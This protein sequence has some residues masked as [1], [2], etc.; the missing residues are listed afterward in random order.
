MEK[1]VPDMYQKSIY[2]ID[3]DKLLRR[4]I[5][6][7]LFDLDNT[8]APVKMKSPT[9][10]IKKFFND[11]KNMGLK[12]II[13]SNSPK[14]R[15]K[16]FKEILEV[17]CAANAHKPNPKKFLQVMKEYDL[18][19]SEIAIIGDQILTDV[20]GGNNVGI[21][22]ILVNPISPVELFFTKINRI[23]ERKIIKK[24]EQRNLFVRGRYY[25]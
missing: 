17:D 18:S 11:L 10:K 20:V 12:V 15:L 22:T 5:K 14:S 23:R 8:V 1:Y 13:F 6:C 25:E 16:P 4:G 24:L 9:K 3:Y 19:V 2:A 7:I 21:T